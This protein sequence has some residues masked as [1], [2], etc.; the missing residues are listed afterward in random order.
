MDSG[1]VLIV[2]G[3]SAISG[4]VLMVALRA[5]R[6]RREALRALAEG[7]GWSYRE[8]RATAGR[9]RR[10]VLAGPT[11]RWRLTLYRGP[12]SSSGGSVQWTDFVAPDAGIPDGLAL[13][14]PPIPEKTA[15]LATTMLAGFGGQV[16]GKIFSGIDNDIGADISRLAFVPGVSPED[17]TLF[18]TSDATDALTPILGHAAFADARR[19]RNER[20]Q[21]IVMRGAFGLKIRIRKELATPEEIE[22][23]VG[24]GETLRAALRH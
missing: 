12:S 10:I 3:L 20:R 1:I 23:L 22:A 17:G 14:G 24:F 19:G 7:N 13:L 18:A 2:I 16:I 11:D 6:Q 8:E 9:G 5:A 4:L 15:Q 21:P